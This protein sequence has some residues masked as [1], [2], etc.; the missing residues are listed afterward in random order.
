MDLEQRVSQLEKEMAD[1][2]RQLE[3][4]PTAKELK[5][6]IIESFRKS[7]L[8]PIEFTSLKVPESEK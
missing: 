1:L 2:K 6:S 8:E 5:E 4:R 3:E 7:C